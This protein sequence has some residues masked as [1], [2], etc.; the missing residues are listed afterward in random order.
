MCILQLRCPPHPPSRDDQDQFLFIIGL[1]IL[2]G[3]VPKSGYTFCAYLDKSMK[4]INPLPEKGLLESW[5]PVA[6]VVPIS[7]SVRAHL[8]YLAFHVQF[9]ILCAYASSFFAGRY[10]W[11]FW[12]FWEFKV[13]AEVHRSISVEFVEF[14]SSQQ[15]LAQLIT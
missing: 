13:K 6:K 10:P 3:N 8:C 7:L 2:P 14:W 12:E 4:R 5:E 11:L 15:F 1:H 9:S